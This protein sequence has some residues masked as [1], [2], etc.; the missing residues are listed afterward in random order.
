M[1]I[2]PL[3][4]G[5]FAAAL[6][7]VGPSDRKTKLMRA[8]ADKIEPST[9]AFLGRGGVKLW[10][11]R[12]AE[13]PPNPPPVQVF[14]ASLNLADARVA[15][16][17]IERAIGDYQRCLDV[18]T[19]N[20]DAR[21]AL[22]VRKRMAIAWM[23][24]GER[25]NCVARHGPES[26]ILPLSGSALHVDRKGSEEAI[27]LFELI[28]AADG[29][30]YGS[31]WLLNLAHMTLGSWPDGVQPLW[32]IPADRFDSEY[33]LPRMREVSA[34]LGVKTEA[35][36]GGSAMDDFDGDGLLDIVVS[37][38]DLREP[39][40]MFRQQ[41][42]RKFR[43]VTKE[44]GLADQWSGLNFLHFDA[45]NDGRLDLLVQRGAWM[46]QEGVLPNSFF[47]QQTDGTFL[48]RTL[49]AGIE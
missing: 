27:K 18:A 21:N 46:M 41:P 8:L 4:P 31:M 44:V 6:L 32:R 19:A 23:R 49:E 47:V 25:M 17:Q 1:P 12:L 16:G 3:I 28:L 15:E 35:R 43:E 39:M 34:Q 37:A 30:D 42:D 7:Q 33:E 24:L 10:E 13:L 48:D 22:A 45:N 9:V 26:C 14:Q 5:L 38:M 40:R 11:R 20:H 36:A 29:D 2:S